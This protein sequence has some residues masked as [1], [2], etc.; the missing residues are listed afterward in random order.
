MLEAQVSRRVA[1]CPRL[2]DTVQP[3]SFVPRHALDAVWE[4][5]IGSR[6]HKTDLAAQT[7]GRSLCVVSWGTAPARRW[8]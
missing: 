7:L 2:R 4:M 6:A 1:R 8:L 5:R 3:Y